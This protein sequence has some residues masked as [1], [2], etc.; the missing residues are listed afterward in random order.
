MRFSFLFVLLSFSWHGV[1]QRIELKSFDPIIGFNDN[2]GELSII[3][4]TNQVVTYNSFG[5]CIQKERIVKKAINF[6]ELKEEFLPVFLHNQLHFVER[7]CGR[8]FK[9]NKGSI[10]RIDRSFSH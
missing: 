7:G 10:E 3:D 8:V 9:F 2:N 6:N 4:D 5:K 1:S